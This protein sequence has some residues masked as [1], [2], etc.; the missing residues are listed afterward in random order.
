MTNLFLKAK[1]WQIFILTFGIPMV[2]QFVAMF[3]MLANFNFMENPNPATLYS[4][5]KYIPFILL[6]FIGFLFMWFWSAGIG[7]QDNIPENAK[8]KTNLFNLF[9]T[10]PILYLLILGMVFS[11]TINGMF[12]LDPTSNFG[13][14]AILFLGFVLLHLFSI[15]CIFYC[16]YFV[17]KTI[18][19]AE[20]QRPVV[21]SDFIPEFF[22]V[23]FS[24]IGIWIL[25]PRTNKL[26]AATEQSDI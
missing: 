13:L 9:L 10:I 11:Y 12:I 17:A 20:L 18:K 5:L 1:H 16:I 24:P 3:S 4:N 15:F 2:F 26:A 19:T 14:I 25:Q 6:L 23:W 22:M 21:F 7:L 8:M